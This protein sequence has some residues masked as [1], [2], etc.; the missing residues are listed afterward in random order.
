MLTVSDISRL[1]A[2]WVSAQQRHFYASMRGFFGHLQ[3]ATVPLRRHC[4]NL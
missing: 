1:V 2:A 3:G 4:G